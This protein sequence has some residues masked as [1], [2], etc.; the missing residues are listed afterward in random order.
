MSKPNPLT[1]EDERAA[2]RAAVEAGYASLDGY[3]DRWEK[4]RSKKIKIDPPLEAI[5]AI[6]TFG[7]IVEGIGIALCAPGLVFMIAGMWIGMGG[8]ALWNRAKGR[9][10]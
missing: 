1:A 5:K 3:I 2:H 6:C 10:K 9:V 4:P 8:G 7:R